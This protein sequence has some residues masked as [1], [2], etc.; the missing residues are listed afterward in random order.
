MARRAEASARAKGGSP[1]LTAK[2]K[3]LAQRTGTTLTLALSG[4]EIYNGKS[5][6]QVGLETAAG[7]AAGAVVTAAAA[8]TLPAWGTAA[9]VVLVGGAVSWGVGK[10]YESWVPLR[11][12]ER[13]DEGIKDAWN[14]TVGSAWKAVFG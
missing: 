11:T 5:P 7:F 14:A 1:T 13:I 8:A 12:R 10:A 6:S 3:K 4:W 2:A 9:V